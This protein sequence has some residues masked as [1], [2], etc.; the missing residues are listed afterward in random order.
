MAALATSATSAIIHHESEPAINIVILVKIPMP[1]GDRDALDLLESL[2]RNADLVQAE[3]LS[4]I[5]RQNAQTECL[6]R[7]RLEGRT[8]GQSFK[9]LLPM[10]TYEDLQPDIQRIH[11]GDTSPILSAFPVSEFLTRY[12]YL[13]LR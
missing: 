6:E 10:V 4:A 7:Y 5:L 1:R 13:H 8:D 9:A 3:M 11:N 2:T 12:I